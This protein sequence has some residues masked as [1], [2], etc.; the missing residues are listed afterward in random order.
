MITDK[1]VLKD[2][3]NHYMS[4]NTQDALTNQFYNTNVGETLFKTY[5]SY[6]IIIEVIEALLEMTQIEYKE[7]HVGNII[8]FER[9]S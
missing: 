6:T 4:T 3:V 7:K 2:F 5:S 8:F 9:I 1:R